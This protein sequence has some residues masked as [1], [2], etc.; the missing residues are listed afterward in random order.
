MPSFEI[1]ISVV[2]LDLGN[3]VPK[4]TKGVADNI[5]AVPIAVTITRSGYFQF[6][7]LDGLSRDLG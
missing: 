5:A 7:N 4:L 1:L 6:G 3:G 2:P